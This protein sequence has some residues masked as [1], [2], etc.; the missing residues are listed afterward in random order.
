MRRGGRGRGGWI[1]L[2]AA[3][4]TAVLARPASAQNEDSD[5]AAVIGALVTDGV[6][7]VD[8]AEEVGATCQSL[9][10]AIGAELNDQVVMPMAIDSVAS[11]RDMQSRNGESPAVGGS[12]AD[13]DAVASAQPV[14]LASG[15]LAVVGADAGASSIVAM[16]INPATFLGGASDP[17]GA[18][19]RSRLMDATVFF[20]VDGLDENDDG[21]IDYFGLRFRV[22]A[23]GTGLGLG[24]PA[25]AERAAAALGRLAREEVN[26]AQGIAAMLRIAPDL[27]GCSRLLL[28]GS[29]NAAATTEVCG[30]LPPLSLEGPALTEFHRELAEL[31]AQIDAE[32]FGLDVRLDFGDPTLGDVPGARGMRFFG[33]VAYGKRFVGADPDDRSVGFRARAGFRSVTLDAPPTAGAEDHLD[34]LEAALGLEMVYPSRF[35]PVRIQA[36]LEGRWGGDPDPALTDQFESDWLVFRGSVSIPVTDT[37]AVTLSFGRPLGDDGTSTLSVSANWGLLLPGGEGSD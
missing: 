1:I 4:L 16:S 5:C 12:V 14:P 9:A 11:A 31:R 30:T 32:Y 10:I 35:Q 21:D 7:D 34:Q 6:F 17:N 8:N 18:D 25:L 28:S 27:E 36:G 2:A 24:G 33:G 13:G 15:A 23:L 3:V 19:K 37:N 22:N 29:A 20:P 26:L